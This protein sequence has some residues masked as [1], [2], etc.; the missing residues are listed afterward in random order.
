MSDEKCQASRVVQD[1]PWSSGEA[2]RSALRV[3][4]L[5]WPGVLS[6]FYKILSAFPKPWKWITAQGKIFQSVPVDHKSN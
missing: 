6:A 1:E 2:A 5:S 3:Q 4:S